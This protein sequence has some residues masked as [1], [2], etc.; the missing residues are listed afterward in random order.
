MKLQTISGKIL[1]VGRKWIKIVQEGKNEK[2]PEDLLINELTSQ[3]KEGDSFTGL[4]VQ[5]DIEK[6]YKGYK[7]S[8]T[9]VNQEGLKQKEIDRWWGYVLS[10][11][12]D[13]KFY[14]KGVEQLH[15]LGCFTYDKEIKR[16]E[17]EIKAKNAIYWI[18]HKFQE[19]GK[20]YQKGVDTLKEL[21]V[22]E[23][24][25][26]IQ[27]IKDEIIRAEIE[28]E[29]KYITWE[30]DTQFHSRQEKGDIVVREGK[31]YK[32]VSSRFISVDEGISYCN[33]YFYKGIDVSDTDEGMEKINIY[34]ENKA[35]QEREREEATRRKELVELIKSTIRDNDVLKAK[36]TNFP[37]GKKILDTF[38]IYGGG[39]MLIV[40]TSYAWY[41]INNGNDGSD[42]SI[43]H[44]STGGAG[45]YGYKC[46]IML[47]KHLLDEL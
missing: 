24:D 2:Y 36:E 39:Q 30:E 38:N 37:N 8:H 43:N 5:T 32:I 28:E 3:L 33:V 34:L 45:A 11:Y 20:L 42:W 31:A 29:S 47:V 21:G 40:D 16:M 23:Y 9:A 7:I 10:S 1:K 44:I 19:Q 15:N 12:K 6:Q 18:R 27:T 13:G 46:D 26:E 4:Q 17:R 41:I 25:T 22:H 14:S 35:I